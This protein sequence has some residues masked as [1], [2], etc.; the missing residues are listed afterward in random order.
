MDTTLPRIAFFGTPDI[1]VW[2]LEELEKSG[3]IPS[4]IIT[5]PDTP[6]GRSLII[7]PSPVSIWAER[8]GIKT[9]KPETLTSHEAYEYLKS[10]QC[11]IFIVAAYGKILP[12]SILD[13]PR[14]GTLNMHPSLLPCLRGASPIRSALLEDMRVTGVS[15]MLLT[16]GMD[17][18]PILA[19][20]EIE[21]SKDEWPLRGDLLD[22]R[23][24]RAGGVLLAN[25]LP[26]WITGTLLPIEQDHT[27]ATYTR[28]ITKEMA[29]IH[30]DDDPYQNL[31]KIKAFDGWPV[32]YFFYERN[33]KRIR[34]KIIDA[35]IENEKLIL[36]RVIPEGRKEMAWDAY[37]RGDGM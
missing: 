11:D 35:C 13:I 1:A 22:E 15:I 24:S 27:R 33:G 8:R 29:E 16:A 19:Q 17:E 28:K 14:Y 37:V 2:V 31:L 9:Y 25:V 5:K 26:Q 20:K 23:L 32:A 34:I 18:G 7:T 12:Q 4:L 21:I 36:L 6:Q 3:I 30:L 10:S